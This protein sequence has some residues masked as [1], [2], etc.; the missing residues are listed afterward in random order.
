MIFLIAA[1]ALGMGAIVAYLAREKGRSPLTW[2]I[3][4]TV[5]APIALPHILI[6]SPRRDDDDD[7]WAEIRNAIQSQSVNDQRP[8]V[9]RGKRQQEAASQ[10]RPQ[11]P[12]PQ[13]QPQQA[14]RE[15]PKD[16]PREP[17]RETPKEPLKEAPKEVQREAQREVPR[18]VQWTVPKEPLREAAHA[19]P[20]A[21]FV[22]QH[23]QTPPET[24]RADVQ[25]EPQPEA[26]PETPAETPIGV[27]QNTAP[28]H[29]APAETRVEAHHAEARYETHYNDNAARNDAYRATQDNYET[30]KP[31]VNPQPKRDIRPDVRPEPRLEPKH[32][33]FERRTPHSGQTR[34]EPSFAPSGSTP[35]GDHG[36]AH[37][38]SDEFMLNAFDRIGAHHAGQAAPQYGGDMR[39]RAP[40]SVDPDSDRARNRPIAGKLFA[41]GAV[42]VALT[43]GVFVLGPTLARM[44]PPE[45]AFWQEPEVKEVANT[46]PGGLTPSGTS[47]DTGPMASVDAPGELPGGNVTNEARDVGTAKFGGPIKSDPKA[48]HY[49][50]SGAEPVD[51]GQAT[52]NL[53]PIDVPPSKAK[54]EAKSES[55]TAAKTEAPKAAAP[56]PKPEAPK[57]EAPKTETKS[58]AVTPAPK[59][60]A[61]KAETPK[62]E[63]PKAEAAK[64]EPKPEPKKV[65]TAKV[66][67]PKAEKPKAEAKPVVAKAAPQEDF[68]SMVN[69]AIS[70]GT[71]PQSAAVNADDQIEQVSAANDLVQSVQIKL[72]ERGYDPGS[73]DGRTNPKTVQA[74]REYQQS[75]GLPADGLIDVALMERLGVV[76]KRLQFPTGGR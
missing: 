57:A 64:P 27:P 32:D 7:V 62:P 14:Y 55:K 26:L 13:R 17:L 71:A 12:Q 23:P 9:G 43:A 28:S 42:A 39:M 10:A 2:A 29:V 21:P 51:L 30:P 48:P 58:A 19:M 44:V 50:G 20:R 6:V 68:L 73:I 61:P 52:R 4:G 34:A 74:I 25:R 16:M 65:E 56:A 18:D 63:A 15:A 45:L 8:I 70:T 36:R 76:G 59:A 35:H 60:E 54:D 38:S 22:A 41:T 3:Y 49:Q 37:K 53:K 46:N 33:M 75:I 40:L 66:T 5:A 31:D 72:R 47:S 11:A 69:K 67:P 1:A 24:P